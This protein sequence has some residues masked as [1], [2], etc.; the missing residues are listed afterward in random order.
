VHYIVIREQGERKDHIDEHI[1]P[2]PS[3]ENHPTIDIP[4]FVAV[5][6]D[7][8]DSVDMELVVDSSELVAQAGTPELEAG[9][10]ELGAGTPELGADTLEPGLGTLEVGPDTLEK[11]EGSLEPGP[12]NLEQEA[13]TPLGWRAGDIH[14]FVVWEQVQLYQSTH[15]LAAVAVSP[16]H[17]D[18]QRCSPLYGSI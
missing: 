11:L 8:L 16:P 2:S 15:R 5:Q 12:D 9:T 18:L 1:H 17:F 7:N 6:V 3:L 10:P 4:D 14:Q 13:G